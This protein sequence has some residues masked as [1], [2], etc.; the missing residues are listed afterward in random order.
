MY[1]HQHHIWIDKIPC[2]PQFTTI[3]TVFHESL[4]DRYCQNDE[5]D[6]NHKEERKHTYISCDYVSNV[7]CQVESRQ[8]LKISPIPHLDKHNQA[9]A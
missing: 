9:R 8:G 4:H 2:V 3:C 1:G 7:H 5:I 6:E